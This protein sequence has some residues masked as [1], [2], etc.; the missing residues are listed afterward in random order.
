MA[1]GS[2]TIT[3]HAFGMVVTITGAPVLLGA[4]AIGAVVGAAVA[5]SSFGSPHNRALQTKVN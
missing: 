1:I 3:M 2:L 5:V 4:F